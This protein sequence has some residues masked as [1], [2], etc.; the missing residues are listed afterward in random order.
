MKCSGQKLET[1]SVVQTNLWYC[2]GFPIVS[3]SCKWIFMQFCK[4]M[5]VRMCPPKVYK[6][7]VDDMFVML[8][9]QLDLNGFCELHEH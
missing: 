9:C 4:T 2:N 1:W 5:A 7:Y 3:D 8:L 6:R